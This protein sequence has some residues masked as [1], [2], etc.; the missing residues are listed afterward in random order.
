MNKKMRLMGK[1]LHRTFLILPLLAIFFI[2][3]F[4]IPDMANSAITVTASGPGGTQSQTVPDAG[5]PF[6]INLPLN[7]NAVNTITVTA[8]DNLGQKASHELKVTQLSLDQI[9]VSQVTAERLSVEQVKQLVSDG[10]IKIDNPANFNVSKFDIVLT[11]G[12]KP[13]PISVAVASAIAAEETGSEEFKMPDADN[14]GPNPPPAPTEIIVFDQP[15]ASEPG[16]P[17]ISIPGVIIIEG[18]I[19]SLK[20][21]YTVR[22]LL[23]NTSGIFTLKNVISNISFPDGGLTSIAPADG[24]ISFGDILPGDGGLPGQAER[25]F[26][27]RGDEI[28]I[29][30][31]KVGF[32]GT[33]AGPGIP[34]AGPVPFNGSAFTKVEVKGPPTF[35]VRA[36]HPD[37]VV[38]GVPYEFKVEITNTG[39]IAALYSSLDLSVGADGKLVNCDNAIP[40]T[41][42]EIGG[43]ETR[44]FGDILPGKTVSAIFTIKPLQTG[45]ITSCV[46]VSD[47]NISLQVIVGLKG[48]LVG[49]FP[50]EQ[51]V[52]D[53]TPTVSVVPTPNTLGVSI[54]S[55]VTAFFSQEMD[56]T[57][58]TTG[59]GGT[60]NV[61]D[62]ANNVVPGTIRKEIINGK[63]VAIWQVQDNITNRLAPNIE[64]TVV[65][66]TAITNTSGVQIYNA[67]TSRFTTTGEALDDVTPP[68][69]T[70]SVEPPVN[71]SYVL[72]GQLVRVNAYAAD[73]GGGVVRVELRIKDL[74]VSDSSYQ[75]VDRKV[76]FAGDLPPYI[77]TIDSANL[78]PGHTYQLMAT[79]YDFMMNGQNATINLAI[80]SSAA[81]PTI[82]LPLPPA[83]GIPQGIS[84]SI[85]PE[86]VT[87]GVNEVR[88]YLDGA[89]TPFKTVNIPPYQAGIGTLTLTL[90]SHTVRAVASDALGQVGEGT[91]VFELVTNPNK[92]QISLSGT[93]DGATYIVGSSFVVNGTAADPLGIASVTYALDGAAVA[94]GNQPFSISTT[95]LALGNHTITA[96]AVNTIGAKSTLTSSFIVVS[97]PNGLP[98]S[99]PVISALSAPTN[100]NVTISGS[101]A[102][103]ASITITNATQKFSITVNANG[104][105]QFSAAIAA[106]SGD[107]IQVIAYDYSASQQPSAAATAA[108]P[109]PPVLTGISADPG[110][111]TFNAANAWQDIT[112]TGSYNNSTTSNLTGQATLFLQQPD[113]CFSKL[114]RQGGRSQERQ[115]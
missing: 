29:R 40:P 87:G 47:Q 28:G 81:A 11:I 3:S 49:Q 19:K 111:M 91:Y 26:I 88:Y 6:D 56:Q 31:V 18:N 89:Q 64:Y 114:R 69:L 37:A 78:V 90:G 54:D 113:S 25:Q 16:R 71:P 35:L 27:I 13:V 86:S 101:S 45:M 36:T 42:T 24:I 52:P 85:T 73:Q 20:E 33:V 100:G 63:T 68:T 98:P 55:P 46:G 109:T 75:L 5:G 59:S 93:T 96:E 15:I 103:G 77:F 23:M 34:E 92:P 97:L 39:D 106:A 12:S 79:A 30:R 65:L 51:G 10:V 21:F 38:A 43:T 50:P 105:G 67:W 94:S 80:A 44:T 22:L 84:V 76:V 99:P 115:Q 2:T 53:G 108:V 9:V 72:P 70:L 112:V 57:T 41:C 95:G 58:I 61:Y 4:G 32:G 82:T 14:Y 62:R 7:R 66:T 1:L 17:Y 104:G 48:C 83:Q 110:T 8:T 60:F 74:S 102:A 107:T